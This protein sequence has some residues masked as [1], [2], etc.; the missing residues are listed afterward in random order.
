MPAA[1]RQRRR[2]QRRVERAR[3]EMPEGRIGARYLMREKIFA[4]GDDFYVENEQQQWVF[5][6]DGKAFRIRNTLK[7]E[8]LQGNEIYKIQERKIRIR[9]SMNIYRG[10][11]VAA[12]VHNALIT[13]LRDRF[14]IEV[15][16][17]PD[18]TT[19]SGRR[20]HP[21][22]HFFLALDR[23][24]S[25]SDR[26][27]PE[28]ITSTPSCVKSDEISSLLRAAYKEQDA[29]RSTTRPDRRSPDSETKVTSPSSSEMTYPVQL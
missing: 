8:D 9:D 25:A 29:P 6:I 26:A 16:G 1:R 24:S 13:P 17:K 3:D 22:D 12:K 27:T 4:I 14:K 19:S 21:G 2:A 23:T 5:K 18:L 15:P 28:S 7:F 10:G 20:G 11:D